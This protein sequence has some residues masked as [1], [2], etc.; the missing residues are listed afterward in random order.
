M[1]GKPLHT[2]VNKVRC[3]L[4]RQ[5][6]KPAP[7]SVV[8]GSDE[9]DLSLLPLCHPSLLMHIRIANYQALIWKSARMQMPEIE[10]ADGHGWKVKDGVLD[11]VWTEEAIFPSE[12]SDILPEQ[13]FVDPE[14]R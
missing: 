5:K 8:S 9:V 7:Q 14:W 2:D 12:L 11:Y 1:Y 6:F 4:I 10:R 13:T 3:D